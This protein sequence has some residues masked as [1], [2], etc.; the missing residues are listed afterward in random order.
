[1]PRKMQQGS[2]TD[3]N[4]AFLERIHCKIHVDIINENTDWLINVFG[5]VLLWILDRAFHNVKLNNNSVK[6]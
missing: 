3:L 2:W 5:N 6:S 4:N 1:M